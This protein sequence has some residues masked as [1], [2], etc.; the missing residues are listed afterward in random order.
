[1]GGSHGSRPKIRI[2]RNAQGY[3]DQGY[4]QYLEREI[5]FRCRKPLYRIFCRKHSRLDVY[6][7]QSA[8]SNK[9]RYGGRIKAYRQTT[10]IDERK[11][12]LHRSMR[13]SAFFTADSDEPTFM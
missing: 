4:L 9:V 2:I 1:M 11:C 6:G 5:P 3:V 13:G 10:S 8:I 7:S 12:F